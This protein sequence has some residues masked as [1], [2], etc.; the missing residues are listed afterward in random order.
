MTFRSTSEV[1]NFILYNAYPGKKQVTEK[2][3]L[4]ENPLVSL[5]THITARKI[6][7]LCDFLL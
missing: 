2:S 4:Q 6:S 3:A 7:W 1:V 5:Y